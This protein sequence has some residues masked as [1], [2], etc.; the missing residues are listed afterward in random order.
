MITNREMYCTILGVIISTVPPDS[1]TR[2]L[3]EAGKEFG[4]SKKEAMT[5]FEESHKTL[6]YVIQKM[7]KEMAGVK[8][9]FDI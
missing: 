9:G 1:R 6:G 5:I 4:I 3:E 2:L 7:L 8:E